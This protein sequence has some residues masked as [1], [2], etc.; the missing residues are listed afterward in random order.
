VPDGANRN[1]RSKPSSKFYFCLDA[2]CHDQ[3]FAISTLRL[4]S[5]ECF[6]GGA[7]N[8]DSERRPHEP[9]ALIS[10]VNKQRERKHD[11][12]ERR[13]RKKLLYGGDYRRRRRR[14]ALAGAS[15]C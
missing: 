15:V 8:L 5:F 2:P 3:V 14:E 11:T 13:S 7:A 10:E 4:T 12:E 6:L 1:L 9:V